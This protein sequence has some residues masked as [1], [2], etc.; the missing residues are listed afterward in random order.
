MKVLFVTTSIPFPP[1]QGIELPNAHIAEALSKVFELDLLVITRS[2][3]DEILLTRRRANLPP[4]IKNLLQ[5]RSYEASNVRKLFQ[6][7]TLRRPAYFI[8]GYT[9]E[10]LNALFLK[11]TYDVVWVSPVGG[12]GLV[13]AC[14]NMG[15]KIASVIA[16]GC[17]DVVTTTYIDSLHEVLSGHLGINWRRI[18]QGLRVP[19]I[20]FH[21]RHYLQSVNLLHVQTP[22][23]ARRA[24]EV[25]MRAPKTPTTIH[26]QNGRK[27]DLEHVNYCADGPL[28]I[29][30]MTHLSGGRA[31]ES[32]WF[33]T[34]VWPRIV[35]KHPAAKLLL[36][37]TPPKANS[38]Y[39]LSLPP[40]AEVLGYV[41]DLGKLYESISLAVVPV[42]NSTGL[43][44][45]VL[46]A[47]TAGVPLVATSAVLAT[48]AGCQS[49]RHAIAADTAK[50]FADAVCELLE[51]A[52]KR[53]VYSAAARVLALQQPTWAETTQKIVN[54]LEY[55]Y[56]THIA[57]AQI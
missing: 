28:R 37:G 6:E 52:T 47:L 14:E 45:R 3:R 20:W 31:C 32:R 44:N 27:T 54:A 16:L 50:D 24:G 55:E 21:E 18:F 36:A 4:T 51:D 11:T 42:V 7:L 53:C 5:L 34:K 48:V 38:R 56:K 30:F 39:A 12:L 57:S 10:A 1:R 26:A 41:N 9:P 17:N 8:E 22:L 29:L 19:W 40:E 15:L 49:G 46:D 43:I 13:K 23:E 35:Q 33:L 2:E 25:L